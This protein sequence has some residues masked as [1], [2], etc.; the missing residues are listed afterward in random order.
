MLPR[1]TVSDSLGETFS[2]LL[3]LV[4][5]F[6]NAYKPS[7]AH[8]LAGFFIKRNEQDSSKVVCY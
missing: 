8:R 6:S 2:L 7:D 5:M 4:S 3:I 1:S